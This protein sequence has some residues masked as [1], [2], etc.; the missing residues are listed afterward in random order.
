[1]HAW[2]MHV[3]EMHAWKTHAWKMHVCPDLLQLSFRCMAPYGRFIELGKRDFTVNSRLE[4]AWFAKN[5][6]YIAVDLGLYVAA[7][8]DAAQRTLDEVMGMIRSGAIQMRQPI[9][10]FGF[11]EVEKAMRVMQSGKHIGKL[12]L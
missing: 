5:V 7:K 1:M 2:K 4:M 10:V 8:P 6:S 11:S 9:S 12:E 3:W